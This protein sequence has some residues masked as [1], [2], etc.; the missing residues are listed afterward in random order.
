METSIRWTEII[1]SEAQRCN[2]KSSLLILV[3]VLPQVVVTV[4]CSQE[5]GLLEAATTSATEQLLSHEP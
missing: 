4:N 5:A 1:H 3:Q 2:V